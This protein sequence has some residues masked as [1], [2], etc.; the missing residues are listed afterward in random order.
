MVQERRF[1]VLIS[2][3]LLILFLASCLPLEQESSSEPNPE[4]M[5][6]LWVMDHSGIVRLSIDTGEPVLILPD[7]HRAR[8]F[9]VDESGAQI[10][11]LL[12]S[13]LQ[14]WNFDG[15]LV[16]DIPLPHAAQ[17]SATLSMDESRGL[18]WLG[19]HSILHQY[20]RQGVH[21]Y[22]V[23]LDNAIIDMD[24]EPDTGTLWV[25]TRHD[26]HRFD[27]HV[28]ELPAH[29]EQALEPDDQG[30]ALAWDS[31]LE[32]VWV[33]S[34]QALARYDRQGAR[35]FL[36]ARQNSRH[37]VPDGQGIL[38]YSDGTSLQRLDTHGQTQLRLD[39]TSATGSPQ[40]AALAMVRA[41]DLH[42][43][44]IWVA[45]KRSISQIDT[46]GALLRRFDMNRIR[47]FGPIL[48][49]AHYADIVP[50]E[51]RI[52]SPQ[53]DSY[54]NS[55]LPLFGLSY[56]DS[57]IGI[58]PESL[59]LLLN[60]SELAVDC[61]H[62]PSGVECYP[63]EPLPDGE[64]R[65]DAEVQDHAGNS[66]EAESIYFSI[67]TAMPL[68]IESGRIYFEYQNEVVVNLYGEP[69]AAE[70]HA[71]L[72]ITNLRSGET[73][74]VTV[75]ANGSFNT[76][77]AA[78][79][80]DTIQIQVVDRAGN[81]S[82]AVE[83]AVP[84]SDSIIPPDPSTLASPLDP[85]RST[86]LAEATAFLY[87]GANPVQ[88]GVVP[89]TIDVR[90]AAVVR[91]RIQTRNGQPLH[92]ATVSLQG[93][94][95][96]GYTVSRRDGLFDLVVNG[97]GVY[98]I[99]Y[100]KEGF[101]PA[102]RK[103]DTP[104]RDY[105]WA[106]DVAL[107]QLDPITTEITLGAGSLQV[108]RG[109]IEQDEDGQR[110]ATLLFSPG[111]QAELV[112]TDGSRQPLSRA[113]VRAT[114]YTVGPNGPKAMPGELPPTSAYTY[115]VELS[116]DEAIVAGAKEVHF[117]RPV[118]V[119]VDNFLGFPVGSLVPAGWYD[120]DRAAWIPSDNGK[121]ISILA[122]EQGLAILDVDGTGNPASAEA[123]AELHITVEERIR[124]A[125]LYPEGKS[126]WRTPIEHFTPI[127]Y[128]WPYGPPG[129]AGPPPGEQPDSRDDDPPQDDDC[130]VS[131]CVINVQSQVLGE[132]IAVRGTPFTLH[133]RSN[134]VPGGAG[135]RL[136][137]RVREGNT[138]ASLRAISVD[139]S[140]AGRRLSPIDSSG[141]IWTFEWDGRDG[142]GRELTGSHRAQ[143][144]LNYEYPAVYYSPDNWGDRVS[145]FA[146][147]G[148]AR[149]STARAAMAVNY[150]RTWFS[151]L[152][153]PVPGLPL[154][155]WSLDVH[156]A[157]EPDARRLHL[158]GGDRLD[159]RRFGSVLRRVT[160]GNFA[161]VIAAPDG[162]W[163][164]A[165]G[166]SIV[167][168][169]KMG[170]LQT[171][172]GGMSR[173]S[174]GDNGPATVAYLNS[175]QGLALDGIGG[176]YIA[177][178]GNHRVRHVNADGII[179]TV[180]GTDEAGF[181]GDNQLA[182]EAQ[183]DSPQDL[184]F[185]QGL[186]LYISDRNN[187]RIRHIGMDG[188][189][190][191]VAGT[192]VAGYSGDYGP[193]VSA[194][195]RF[196]EGIAVDKQGRLYIADT[197]NHRLRRLDPDGMIVTVAGTGFSG[198]TGDGGPALSAR[199]SRPG[200][201]A[202]GKENTIYVATERGV[203]R[204][205]QDGNIETELGGG[206][207][208][209]RDG[210]DA[211]SLRLTQSSPIAVN[212]EGTL[213]VAI[214]IQGLSQVTAALPGVGE[215][216][217]Y[218][219]PSS[220]RGQLYHFD[221]HGRHLRTI[222]AYTG[223]VLY[224]F[225]YDAQGYLTG[226]YDLVNRLT[227][228]ERNGGGSPTA[229]V[230]PDGH[231]TLLSINTDGWLNE[232]RDPANNTHRMAY[233][234]AGL[235]VSYTNPRG[236]HDR[237]EYDINGRLTRNITPNGGGWQLGRSRTG[238][239]T[240]ISLQ[241]G[242]GRI[243]RF[244]RTQEPGGFQL[245]HVFADGS[246]SESTA[247]A[248]GSTQ[249]RSDGTAIVQ[250]DS[251]DPIYGL[252]APVTGTRIRTSDGLELTHYATREVT[253]QS[254]GLMPE[255]F[256][257]RITQNN[258][259]S[260]MRYTAA[261]QRWEFISP[262]GRTLSW[263]LNELAQP[264]Q[265]SQPGLADTRIAYNADGRL[266]SLV[267]QDSNELRQAQFSYH[268]NG[269]QRGY[270]ASI[271]DPMGRQTSLEYDSAGRVTQQNLPDGRAIQYSY[272]PNSN[273]TRLI[274]PGGNPHVFEYD[275]VDQETD[276]HPPELS[277][278]LT[279]TRYRYNLD[280]DLTEV[281]RPD[282]QTVNLNYTAGGKLDSLDIARGQY[283]YNYH[284][285]TGQLESITAADGGT[286]DFTWDSFLPLTINW[287]GEVSGTYRRSYD[288]Y[289][290]VSSDQVNNAESISRV[291][292]GDGLL[293]RIGTLDLNR[294]M[295]NGLLRTSRLGS[296]G[297]VH[298]Y[299]AF[300]EP[301]H[302]RV[303]DTTPAQPRLSL[304]PSVDEVT[305]PV[306]SIEAELEGA[307]E[308]RVNQQALTPMGNGRFAGTYT[309]PSTGQN[310][311][312]I[313]LH[314]MDGTH[315]VSQGVYIHYLA[316]PGLTA[317]ELL[318]V[319]PGQDIYYRDSQDGQSK[320]WRAGQSMPEVISWLD[321]VDKVHFGPESGSA[322]YVRNA[323]VWR[324]TNSQQEMIADLD[325][326][327]LDYFSLAVGPGDEVYL[328]NWDGVY[329]LNAD[330]QFQWLGQEGQN[331][332]ELLGSAWGVVVN[333]SSAVLSER[334]PESI[335]YRTG[336]AILNY[337]LPAAHAWLQSG[338]ADIYRVTPDGLEILYSVASTGQDWGQGALRDDGTVCITASTQL[339][340]YTPNGMGE[341]T[342]L[343]REYTHGLAFGGMTL[344]GLSEN[345]VY[346]IEGSTETLMG[347]LD[348]DE[349]TAATLHVEGGVATQENYHEASYNRD[350]LGRI[351]QKTEVTAGETLNDSYEYDL[352][353]RLISASRNGITTTWGYDDNG[354]RSHENGQ[355][356]AS[357]DEQDRLVSYRGASYDYTEN[358][359]LESKTENGVT[360]RY[361][362]DELGNLLR[363]TLPG[364]MSIDYLIDGKNRRIGKKINGSLTQGFLYQDQLN[365][366]AELD[367]SGAV[368][369]RFVY[370]DKINVPA[371]MIRD[372]RSYRIISDHLGS[373]RLVIDSE[374]GEIAQR[375]SY[376][377]WGNI[378]EDTNPGF[379]PFGFAGGIYDQH[380]GLVRF[381]ARDYDPVTARWT[382]K[383]PIRFA[384][385]DVNLYGYV[386]NNP[387]NFIDPYGLF[388]C[389]I[390]KG[391][392]NGSIDLGVGLGFG[393][394]ASG[395]LSL[396]SSGITGSVTA[397]SSF[398]ASVTAGYGGSSNLGGTA[399]GFNI[400]TSTT[401][402]GGNG[403][404]GGAASVDAGT[405]GLTT[406]GTVG[407]GFGFNV[408]TGFNISGSILDCEE[409]DGCGNK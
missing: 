392:D 391:L 256:E 158:G 213:Y 226:I 202:L 111:T 186:G 146:R 166:N 307:V 30:R 124:L 290:R 121:V 351:T 137:V 105:V 1:A 96:L 135:N 339:V 294:D 359:E 154:N 151:Y 150:T 334:A 236:E 367:A 3:L 123:L 381:G 37:L 138:P 284:S 328:S 233:T 332:A 215:E 244:E 85:T 239:T 35:T 247:N 33:A 38:W 267:Q 259:T 91:G 214:R 318:G 60:Q 368:I 270:L 211:Q 223:V 34:E 80:E 130:E 182:S 67:D 61:E 190:T 84:D 179:T 136:H 407:Y 86:S 48:A 340:C 308:V 191:T 301:M 197:A 273:L 10:W 73:M 241:S 52:D 11:V 74:T 225:D 269:H 280:K 306:V 71:I 346:R 255:I 216:S 287:N 266:Q 319:S 157:Y 349:L 195:L 355:L 75:S 127:D 18:I 394:G 324:H 335:W 57:G 40:I 15:E 396:S 205:M 141:D 345:G 162:G 140:I 181:G 102:Q 175:P 341:A 237:F 50:P 209:Y 98:T 374:S 164:M 398:G 27:S 42:V 322:Y 54:L 172:A 106:E 224:R 260:R 143:V 385:G 6:A 49:I 144:R 44:D 142:F 120:R 330:G 370:A 325:A 19:R 22:T 9:V 201:L 257:E 25:L 89:G 77:L 72:Q 254:D 389:S 99:N 193:G 153:A 59:R 258:Q 337:L 232:L 206:P 250:M 276:Y 326:Q 268:E 227:R 185:Y 107:I 94:P 7:T 222:E 221:Q 125:G 387:I 115:A 375:I 356:V 296:V 264:V 95:E 12:P 344:Y 83:I 405:N 29:A 93:H 274:P 101:L 161:S 297:T 8:A 56:S 203:R 82:P 26:L 210:I 145:A 323:R 380:T 23:N 399:G 298:D 109:S 278:Q 163:L 218:L 288:N 252:T 129:D 41:V 100:E 404:A 331:R 253:L 384:G 88:R 390:L 373:P 113:T 251:A 281:I 262:L 177:D 248:Y 409:D 279:P 366:V 271:I 309:L 400:G 178:T 357:Y 126:L 342:A 46:S 114:E 116:L 199:L 352:A 117:D 240:T 78:M 383:D 188:V 4:H 219:I 261:D 397:G 354:N 103:V 51:I 66:A 393:L 5:S 24:V 55:P 362:Y 371:Y 14:A 170:E 198:S 361:D 293:T 160:T 234:E 245:K 69:G 104:W 302:Y 329:H 36:Q 208:D 378:T 70:S 118:H 376:D 169:S 277:G 299:N 64:Y 39:A 291:Y 231:R 58:N 90:R 303:I 336:Q 286:L 350:T 174:A 315:L 347:E 343:S 207:E 372:G 386:L 321:G 408:T 304:T 45:G 317:D 272:D 63:Q 165:Q 131:G 194:A 183:L 377:V 92:G 353:G 204:V 152:S 149:V 112:M 147:T 168:L 228:I 285:D 156:H 263:Q 119:Y 200:H 189:I 327:G 338:G 139:V 110:Q 403:V 13:K 28:V 282:G 20:N 300:G 192:G 363:V 406:S 310:W 47:G 401:V 265:I 65:L 196:P 364:D 348:P 402:S 173:G 235:M 382:S 180:A 316:E 97:G 108:A 365:P 132:D 217:D 311:V 155:A 388:L 171:V 2:A 184:A 76:E 295:Q 17:D 167:H 187:H 159:V 21:Q 238:N 379:Q 134:R 312:N 32:S 320:V 289:F 249:S 43:T 53:E 87:T 212:G 242:E 229:I 16:H 314:D 176:F 133:Y 369:N 246:E 275:A 395:S 148:G 230:S 358:G 122:I 313:S 243:S 292:D 128:N 31:S 333:W 283:R 79:P 68:G 220:D 305:D 81:Q 360:T 62:S